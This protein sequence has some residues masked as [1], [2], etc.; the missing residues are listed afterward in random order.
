MPSDSSG[1]SRV[2]PLSSMASAASSSR[3]SPGRCCS[4]GAAA[5]A[6]P[7]TTCP[8]TSPVPRLRPGHRHRRRPPHPLRPRRSAAQRRATPAGLPRSAR[9]LRHLEGADHDRHLG[10]PGVPLRPRVPLHSWL[11]LQ[12]L[13]PRTA[14]ARRRR[15]QNVSPRR[16]P[17][18]PRLRS[19]RPRVQVPSS[20]LVSSSWSC[21][22]ISLASDQRRRC[23]SRSV[24]FRATS[25]S[26]WNR[27]MASDASRICSRVRRIMRP[28]VGPADD[29]GE[30][31]VPTITS[32][33]RSSVPRSNGCGARSPTAPPTIIF[34]GSTRRSVT[35]TSGRQKSRPTSTTT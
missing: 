10:T 30:A 33:K 20:A 15:N 26:W 23:S 35:P 3:T 18:P 21:R 27:S 9:H 8:T 16:T 32:S 5:R 19:G 29:H 24:V 22:W 7:P 31:P 4:S 25:A 28:T 13:A 2:A 34:G 17:A 12:L 6:A 14:T 11:P 1:C